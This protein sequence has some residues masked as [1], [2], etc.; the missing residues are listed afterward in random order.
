MTYPPLQGIRL[1]W[2]TLALSLAVFMEVLDTTI[3]NVAVPVIA[4][5]LGAATTQG[6]W[7]I[8]SFAV[9]NAISV[10]LTGFLAK[11]MGEVRLFTASV[12]GFVVMSWLCGIAPNLQL[13]VVFR[14]LQGF[15]AGPLI[16]LS[17]SLLMASYPREKRTLALAL[18]AMT[19][20]VAPV[21]GPILGGWI[22]NNWHWG[23]IFFIN[24]PIGI[25]AAWI[26]WRQL[27]DRETETVKT[28][29]DY[30][31]LVLMIVGI[32]ALQMM[33]D[34]GKELDWFASAEIMVLGITA[35]ITLTYFIV[36]ELGEK[37][38]I[39][40]LSLFKNRNFAIGVLAT[41]LG[42]MVYMG[43]LTL[44]PLVLQSNLGYTSTWAGL[45]AAPVGLLP[46]LLSPVIGKFGNRIDMRIL[47]TASFLV[48][49]FAFHW[50][51]DFYAGMDISNVVWPQFWQGLGVAMFFL[52]LTTI[53][54]SHIEGGRIASASSLSNFLRVFMGGV[55]V[56]VVSTM[57]ERREALHHTRLAE[58][59]NIY[60]DHTQAALQQMQQQGM[61]YQQA[62][63]SINGSIT[64]QGFIIGSNEI[65]FAGSILFVL[66][67]A[68][69]WFAKPPFGS[70][71]GGGH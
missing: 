17:Q 56:S 20:V 31:G 21:L 53:T 64:Q 61:T 58:H 50:R 18:W 9:A 24:V 71:G 62:L 3:A 35:L 49:A 39:V 55:G 63:G 70:K 36:W 33:L 48:F 60:S 41:S 23:W 44:L 26:A 2:V 22:S 4:G 43:T 68:V 42:F 5:D 69:I 1:V 57:W 38:P 15:I 46:V 52:P 34:R 14:V 54:L 27:A 67:I 47:V 32:G 29:I 59:V 11:R 25:A 6:T 12:I 10:P 13:L 8:T 28:P 45:A 37:Y 65:F 40:D 51:T 16:P 66:M 19:V 30:V 7:V